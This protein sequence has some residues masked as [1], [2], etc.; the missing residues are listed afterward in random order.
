MKNGSS[1][2]V[3]YD[4]TF[5]HSTQTEIALFGGPSLA[6]VAWS[7]LHDPDVGIPLLPCL[8]ARLGWRAPDTYRMIVTLG[9]TSTTT[10]RMVRCMLSVKDCTGDEVKTYKHSWRD[11]GP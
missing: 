7:V 11:L 5:V 8:V 6:L 10:V 1:T 2:R 9:L 3:T 4:C